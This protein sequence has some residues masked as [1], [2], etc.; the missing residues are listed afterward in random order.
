MRHNAIDANDNDQHN[1]KLN[2][3]PPSNTEKR[4]EDWVSG[5]DPMTGAQGSYLKTLSE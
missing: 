5:S 2:P 3:A 1:P 4:P